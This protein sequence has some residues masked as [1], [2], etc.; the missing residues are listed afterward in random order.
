MEKLPLLDI[1]IGL[2][3]IYTFLSLLASAL[4]ELVV[5]AL[6]WRTKYLQQG[7]ITLLGE[8]F[9]S[10]DQFKDSI[11]GRLWN[12]PQ[13]ISAIRLLNRREQSSTFSK[14]VPQLFAAA[15]LDILQRLP[16]DSDVSSQEASM[17]TI[18]QL[19]SIVESSPSLSPQLQANL[20][21]LLNRVQSIEADSEQQRL[22]LQYE[23]SL[24]FNYAITDAMTA[25]KHQFKLVSFLVSLVLVIAVNVDSLYIIRRI[26]E[27]TATRAV[28]MQNVLHIQGCQDNLNSSACQ[29]HL[30]RLMETSTI[31]VGWQLSNRQ[32]Q[33]PQLSRVIVL[34]T[35]GGWS[36][37][38]IAVAMGSR[39]W[40]QILRRM[41]IILRVGKLRQPSHLNRQKQQANPKF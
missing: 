26:S 5:S 11:T 36:L 27:N 41:G 4:T 22:R 33:F 13:V 34:R 18:S 28:I 7:L 39:F 35:I 2:S 24:W 9:V 1:V 29:H 10:P 32:R 3:L 21:Q 8:S 40:L 37:T 15:L 19:R 6:Q 14:K 17:E 25:Y 30:S 20:R 16:C 23:L 12:S 31:P 38:G